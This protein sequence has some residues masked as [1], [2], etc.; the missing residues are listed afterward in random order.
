MSKVFQK[1]KQVT[2][3]TVQ[4]HKAAGRKISMITCY[5]STFAKIID[6]TDIDL[7]LVG[8]SLGNVML[9]FNN[10]IP[11]T[12][13]HMIHHTAAVARVTERV[14]LV[15]D[16]PFMSYQVSREDAL[17]NAGRLMKEGGAHAVKLEGGAAICPTVTAIVA[18]GI[19]VMGHLGLTPQSIHQI[20]GYRVQGRGDAARQTLLADALALQAAGAFALV[21]EMVPTE[22]AE[23]VSNALSIPT[24]GIGAGAGCGGQVLVLHDMLGFDPDFNP[25][26]L[27]KYLQLGPMIEHALGEYH[28]DVLA[29]RFPAPEHGYPSAG[30][31]KI[32]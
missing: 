22:L 32:P 14:L 20:G 28:G 31:V 3:A 25:R 23:E 5:D 8:D 9:G 29:G 12:V 10:T 30:S 19:P 17:H 2:T 15:A 13:D 7:V 6:R 4:A 27:K 18:A 16:M 11:V 21:L 26:F 1:T 24:I